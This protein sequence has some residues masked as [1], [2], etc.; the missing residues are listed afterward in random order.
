M[1]A[2]HKPP[3]RCGPC[4]KRG[5][6]AVQQHIAPLDPSNLPPCNNHHSRH[7]AT[8]A[9][10]VS[11]P[12]Q[13]THA[14]SHTQIIHTTDFI[15]NYVSAEKPE[16]SF[17]CQLCPKAYRSNSAL[18]RHVRTKHPENGRPGKCN[19]C[20]QLIRPS[21]TEQPAASIAQPANDIAPSTHQPPLPLL[22]PPITPPPPPLPAASPP[23]IHQS[24]PTQQS[25]LAAANNANIERYHS[26]ACGPST[27][28]ETHH[29]GTDES[30]TSHDTSMQA[31]V[32]PYPQVLP[33]DPINPTQAI[34]P[35]ELIL[36]PEPELLEIYR[37]NWGQ[38]R[39]R[40]ASHCPVQ[41]YY[42]VRLPAHD[43]RIVRILIDRLFFQ[44]R[45]PFR[46]SASLGYIL[47][48][49]QSGKLR[50]FHPSNNNSDLIA[51]RTIMINSVQQVDEIASRL[52]SIDLGQYVR[53]LRPN[54]QWS[55]CCITNCC[56][57]ITPLPNFAI[58]SDVILPSFYKTEM[59]KCLRSVS[60][61][62]NLCFFRS[63]ALFRNPHQRSNRV[64]TIALSL[65]KQVYKNKSPEN[66]PGIQLHELSDISRLFKTNI[67]IYKLNRDS[68]GS[69]TAQLVFRTHTKFDNTMYL[70]LYNDT[71]FSLITN[72]SFY[73]RTFLCKR[74][75][76]FFDS[77]K[78][79]SRHSRTCEGSVKLLY[80]GG[81]FKLQKTVFDE[82]EDYLDI[83]F[84]QKS[85]VFPHRICF[86]FESYFETNDLPTD[87]PKVSWQA[88]HLPISVSLCSNVKTFTTPKCFIREASDLNGVGLLSNMVEYILQIQEH[89]SAILHEKYAYIFDDLEIKMTCLE[90]DFNENNKEPQTIISS[91]K[92]SNLDFNFLAY[93]SS[94]LFSLKSASK[95]VIFI[96][97]S[98][99]I[100]AYFS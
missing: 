7:P 67:V 51:P 79:L 68:K 83:Q 23:A 36:D 22:P 61:K 41:N 37:R 98:S 72:H 13:H 47:R 84:P 2:H 69:R 33:P 21:P 89:S 19:T 18:K 39:T 65:F 14:P 55:V 1:S 17:F 94:L 86:D 40:Y 10:L 31:Q 52:D 6:T 5:T 32:I 93:C 48:H 25:V 53:S 62:F 74:C 91:R 95:Q 46:L 80:P 26:A 8:A 57:Y 92:F 3:V 90:A 85:R 9:N 54:T 29:N 100:Y 71:H 99:N 97:K 59:K 44:A 30:N 75:S 38:I 49:N 45:N 43:L 60:G 20:G 34:L 15:L 56:L 11:F 78:R 16:P 27:S 96:S 12:P 76:K 64:E 70:D 24:S 88:K 82:L 81:R 4:T 42:N 87:T 73:S 35:E 63:L 66:Y 50:Y 77:P 28:E 58:G